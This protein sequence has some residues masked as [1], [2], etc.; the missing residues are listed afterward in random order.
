MGAGKLTQEFG[1]WTTVSKRGNRNPVLWKTGGVILGRGVVK[2][3][4]QEGD[5][6]TGAGR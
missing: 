1:S 5:I 4:S 2:N 3:A 6:E